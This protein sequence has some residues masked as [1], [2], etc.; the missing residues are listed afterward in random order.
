[1]AVVMKKKNTHFMP[2]NECVC[3]HLTPYILS[4]VIHTTDLQMKYTAAGINSKSS[5]AAH[6]APLPLT[7]S[8]LIS[9]KVG[10]VC[11]SCT[12]LYL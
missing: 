9:E 1:M 6:T 5:N 10:T 11:C 2:A 3:C 7:A 4:K 12:M 8:T